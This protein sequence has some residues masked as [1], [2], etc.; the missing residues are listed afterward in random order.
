[1]FDMFTFPKSKRRRSLLER[2]ELCCHQCDHDAGTTKQW[3]YLY[4]SLKDILTDNLKDI[5][6]LQPI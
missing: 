1:M 3:Q 2:E 4:K 6:A 5:G